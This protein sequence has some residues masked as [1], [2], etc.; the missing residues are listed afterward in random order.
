LDETTEFLLL[1]SLLLE[2]KSRLLLPGRY[3]D[4]EEELSPEAAR[5]QLS[6][7]SSSTGGFRASR[8]G[9]VK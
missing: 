5:D 1:M 4:L 9:F 7:G 8:S 6:R 3:P 2:V